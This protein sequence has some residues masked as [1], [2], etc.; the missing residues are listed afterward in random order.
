[1]RPEVIKN[2]TSGVTGTCPG[3]SGF[4]L[5]EVLA[6]A[7]ILFTALTVG[8]VSYNAS[9]D[10]VRRSQSIARISNVVSN[11]KD[12][13]KTKLDTGQVEGAYRLT[14][15]IAYTWQARLEKSSPNVLQY[16]NEFADGIRY[17]NF[18]LNLF[19]V[20]LTITLTGQGKEHISSYNYLELTWTRHQPL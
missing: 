17:G 15:D 3:Q 8:A 16:D 10:F 5:I 2:I 1:M 7:L 12:Q 20:E 18:Q 14:K 9:L 6:A 11:I 19:Q 13:I 4:T